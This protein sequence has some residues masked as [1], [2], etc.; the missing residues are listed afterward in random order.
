MNSFDP[1]LRDEIELATLRIDATLAQRRA[2]MLTEYVPAR[3]MHED[4]A[5]LQSFLG[6]ERLVARVGLCAEQVR[7]VY[8]VAAGEAAAVFAAM[9]DIQGRLDAAKRLLARGEGDD[10]DFATR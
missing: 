1:T 8:G 3:L 6:L 7:R 2:A 4:A 9:S 10:Y 5:A